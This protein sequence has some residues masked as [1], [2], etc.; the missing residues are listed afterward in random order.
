MTTDEDGA[1]GGLV[2]VR[3]H[4]RG[5]PHGVVS[6]SDYNRSP[7]GGGGSAGTGGRVWEKQNNAEF[8]HAIAKAE[9]SAEHPNHGYRQYNS[10]GRGVGALGRYQ[11][12][13]GA[14]IEAGWMDGLGRWTEKAGRFG[15]KTDND[16]LNHPEAQGSG[17]DGRAERL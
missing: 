8:R 11:L 1:S 4:S 17:I 7:P 15:I 14:L 5:S 2:H 9:G 3:G 6:V 10:A 16:F 12:R 13:M